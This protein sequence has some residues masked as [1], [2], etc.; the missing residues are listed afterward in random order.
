MHEPFLDPEI[1]EMVRLL[2]P[3]MAEMV[4]LLDQAII[5]GRRKKLSLNMSEVLANVT[6]CSECGE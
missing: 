6:K 5:F 3:E 4:Q 2:D 1:A